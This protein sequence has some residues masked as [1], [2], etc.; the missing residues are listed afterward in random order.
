[1][2]LRAP[3][4]DALTPRVLQLRLAARWELA[5]RSP[6]AFHEFLV[7]TNRPQDRQNIVTPWPTDRPHLRVLTDCWQA[8]Q[9]MLLVKCRQMLA[10]WW[11]SSIALWE[12]LCN[13]HRLIMLQSKRLE[14]VI[15]DPNTGDGLLGRA[16]FILHHIPCHGLLGIKCAELSD[17]IIF[18]H[19]ESTLWGIPQGGEI[20]RQRTPAGIV[21]DE[22]AFQEEF[23][24]SFT[25]T[26]P[27]IR[28]GGWFVGITTAGL[29]DGG[30]TRKL[31]R[32]ELEAA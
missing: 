6:H 24:D 1:M 5:R 2:I 31:F 32:D 8:H 9:M 21:S 17:R 7:H 4:L 22:C 12:G 3:I 19:T 23:E 10:T 27:C 15:G 14:D 16:K 20:I 11:A 13:P 18:A 26:T 29:K 25:A 28:A 30:F